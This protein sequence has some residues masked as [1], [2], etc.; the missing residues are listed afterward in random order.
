M[1]GQKK[2][3]FQ[4]RLDSACELIGLPRFTLCLPQRMTQEQPESVPGA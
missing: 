1:L 2:T 3:A 4:A